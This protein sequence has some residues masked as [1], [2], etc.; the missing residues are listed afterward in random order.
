MPPYKFKV[1]LR[2]KLIL[3]TGNLTKILHLVLNDNTQQI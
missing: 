3:L 1:T 2:N